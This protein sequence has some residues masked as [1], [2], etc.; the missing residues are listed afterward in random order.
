MKVCPPVVPK[1]E[2]LVLVLKG[3]EEYRSTLQ[4]TRGPK[5]MSMDPPADP[6]LMSMDPPAPVGLVDPKLISIDPPV[7]VG[8]VSTGT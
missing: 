5:W 2:V 3:E 1:K 8:L 4:S 7:P 6:K